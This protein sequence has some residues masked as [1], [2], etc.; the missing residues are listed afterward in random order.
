MIPK[1]IHYCWF[2]GK[3][4][5]KEAKRCIASWRKYLPDYEIKEWNESNFDVNV[6]PY[7]AEAYQAKKYAFVSD[8]ARLYVLHKQGG[9]YFDTDVEVIRNM[10]S[11]IAAGPFMGCEEAYDAEAEPAD[12]GVNPGLG[13][14]LDGPDTEN[15]EAR[16]FY[17]ELLEGYQSRHFSQEDPEKLITIVEYTTK[18]LCE[19]GL[20]HSD[21]VQTVAGI[22]IYPKEYFCP[23]DRITDQCTKTSNTVSIHHYSASWFPQDVIRRRHLYNRLVKLFGERIVRTSLAI[24]KKMRIKK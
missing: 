16:K 6:I 7:T 14:G 23:I 3:P 2:G 4:L 12:M 8:Y 10:D 22:Q 24:C 18:Y 5:P 17:E 9:L 19:H 13:I 20:K 21:A 11:I 1:I 15:S